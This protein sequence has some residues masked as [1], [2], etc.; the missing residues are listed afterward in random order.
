VTS[1]NEDTIT[2][3]QGIPFNITYTVSWGSN[4]QHPPFLHLNDE[5]VDEEPYSKL[6]N[7]TIRDEITDNFQISEKLPLQITF[8]GEIDPEEFR[9]KVVI[10]TPTETITEG[11]LKKTLRSVTCLAD[12]QMIRYAN[13]DLDVKD[14]SLLQ[15]LNSVVSIIDNRTYRLT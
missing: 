1:N 15:N 5:Y 9:E 13:V 4:H 3:A 12:D 11:S 14:R 7:C 10:A 6:E 8:D 2:L